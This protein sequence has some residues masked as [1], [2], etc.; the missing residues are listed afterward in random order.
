[1]CDYSLMHFPNRLATEG[2]ELLVHR[3]P[4]G[5]LGLASPADLNAME[6]DRSSEP[7]SFWAS[8]K[9]FLN[10]PERCAVPAVCVPPGAHLRLHNIG[11]RLC[12]QYE[13]KA[14]EEVTFTQLTAAP[15]LY[16]DAIVV[17]NGRTLRLQELPEG[18]HV[19]VLTL[20]SSVHGEPRIGSPVLVHP[21]AVQQ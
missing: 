11:E 14:E 13:L 20:A 15:N 21:I 8:V 19:T 9:E 2:E 3:F 18:Q 1:M 5:S 17:E 16:R 12:R 4:S 10:P 7:R 6:R